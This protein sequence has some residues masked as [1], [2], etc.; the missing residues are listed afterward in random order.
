MYIKSFEDYVDYYEV[1]IQLDQ[2]IHESEY[3]AVYEAVNLKEFIKEV[4]K[5]IKELFDK[6]IEYIKSKFFDEKYKE[7][8]QK[9]EDLSKIKDSAISEIKVRTVFDWSDVRAAHLD[10]IEK[11][12]A[13]K[14]EEQIAKV[15]E[16]H[17][18]DVY[19][20]CQNRM[21]LSLPSFVKLGITA[22]DV[23]QLKKTKDIGNSIVKTVE[24]GEVVDKIGDGVGILNEK[25]SIAIAKISKSM[26]KNET[27][28]FRELTNRIDSLPSATDFENDFRG[29]EMRDKYYGDIKKKNKK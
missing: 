6:C 22:L 10:A 14:S 8:K 17:D 21:M 20:L 7:R 16:K 19:S 9:L 23:I 2:L 18:K 27:N 4:V 12:K 11:I 13:A 24:K 3:S 26:T 25:K 1:T 28:Y 29:H 5:K 15:L